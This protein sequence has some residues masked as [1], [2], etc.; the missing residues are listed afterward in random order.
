MKRPLKPEELR[1]WSLVAATVH[2]LPG[3]ATP[4]RPAP[5]TLDAPARI[6]PKTLKARSPESAREGVDDIE[7]NRK[8]RIARERDPIGARIDLHGMIQDRARAA[9]EAFL[10]RAWDEGYRAVL[11]ITGK[12]VQGD[13]VLRRQAPEWLAASH[14][15]H[16]VAGVSEAH[17]R[18]GGA[19]ALYVALKRKPRG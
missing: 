3:K 5:Q 15:A 14:L 9:L 10:G 4:K 8:T 6:D 17:R 19:G 2:P 12:G 1:I 18:H 7:P 16:I 13:G 11:V